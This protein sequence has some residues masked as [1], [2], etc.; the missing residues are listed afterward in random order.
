MKRYLET[1]GLIDKPG[2]SLC[3]GIMSF[4]PT[5]A[6]FLNRLRVGKS[7]AEASYSFEDPHRCV[8]VISVGGLPLE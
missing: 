5:L 6:K 2:E 1:D 8:Y 7:G 4:W 3:K